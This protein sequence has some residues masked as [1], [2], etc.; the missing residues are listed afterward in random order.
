MT[1][2]L[3]SIVFFLLLLACSN[4]TEKAV[5]A[6]DAAEQIAPAFESED[7]LRGYNFPYVLNTKAEECILPPALV[8]I[9]GLGMNADGKL[10]SINDEQGIC[11]NFDFE[12]CKISSKTEFARYGDFEGV[13]IVHPNQT[14]AIK[15]NGNI[16][17]LQNGEAQVKEIYN[18]ALSQ[19]NDVEGLGYDAEKNALIIACKGSASLSK[20]SRKKDTKAV[21]GFSL[22][23]KEL[24]EDPI[25]LIKDKD[26]VH[27]VE[28]HVD[29]NKM[30]KKKFKNLISRVRDFSP[31]GIAVHPIDKHYYILSSAGKVLLVTAPRGKILHAEFLDKQVHVQPEGICFSPTGVLYI[32]N[33]GKSAHGKIMKYPYATAQ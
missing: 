18:T 10:V 24:L 29:V 33:E 19:I 30:S 12:S 31:S 16:F 26:L 23:T 4:K 14:F 22:E 9:S 20:H 3:F 2:N 25:F 32:A 11:F 7:S 5:P 8:E 28:E 17:E 27:W 13:E 15:S 6:V 1:T 21:F